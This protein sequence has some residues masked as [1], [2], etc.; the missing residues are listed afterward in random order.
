MEVGGGRVMLGLCG[1][2]AHRG[3]EKGGKST[4]SDRERENEPEERERGRQTT[5]RLTHNHHQN[6]RNA[7]KMPNFEGTWKMKSSHNFE[8]LLKALGEDGLLLFPVKGLNVFKD[9]ER[10]IYMH[11]R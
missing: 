2:T 7:R 11:S 5:R 9:I 10:L 8:E 4:G 1:I 6:H 3:G